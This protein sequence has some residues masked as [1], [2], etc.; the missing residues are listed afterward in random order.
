[1]NIAG[2]TAAFLGAALLGLSAWQMSPLLAL[3]SV[4][5]I[6]IEGQEERFRAIVRSARAKQVVGWGLLI[7]GFV[8]QLLGA[9]LT[10][11]PE[12]FVLPIVTI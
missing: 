1:M 11:A 7:I 2:L 8:L 3:W 10:R 6:R 4:N 12:V 9:I 5:F